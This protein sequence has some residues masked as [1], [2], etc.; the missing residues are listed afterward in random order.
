MRD[1]PL[2]KIF[3]IVLMLLGFVL[4]FIRWFYSGE[5]AGFFLWLIMICLTL[6]RWRVPHLK[7]TVVIDAFLCALLYPWALVLA[8]FSGFSYGMFLSAAAI[9]FVI[10]EPSVV[11]ISVLGGLGGLFLWFWER[12]RV[13]GLTRRDAEAGKYYELEALQSDLHAATA[14]VERMTAVSERA[15]IAR[16]IHDNA[17]HEIVAA[18]ISLQ[19]ARGG[20][21]ENSCDAAT[22]RLYDAA[23]DRLDAG[24]N[25]IREAVHNLAPVA[26][27]GVE[28]LHGICEN[29]PASSIEFNNFGDTNHIPVHVWSVLESCLQE[30]LTNAAK[31]AKESK[32]TVNLDATPHLVRLSVEN[33]K[34]QPLGISEQLDASKKNKT[35]VHGSGLRNLRHRAFA[36]GGSFSADSSAGKFRVVCVVPLEK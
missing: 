20:F 2:T 14:Q 24:V 4:L 17:G 15:R 3:Y 1:L 13:R 12:E 7:W 19:T 5:I 23:L 35:T 9:I 32:V 29:F 16:E 33:E 18:F 25:K 11:A 28:S 34:V 22:L 8:I 27:I 26:S 31:Y 30:A 6:L 10:S 21:D 36:I